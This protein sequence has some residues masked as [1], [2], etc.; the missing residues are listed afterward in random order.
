MERRVTSGAAAGGSCGSG[1]AALEPPRRSATS[2]EVRFLIRPRLRPSVRLSVSVR[3]RVRVRVSLGLELRVR[4]GVETK[5][6]AEL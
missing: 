3:V 2:D 6:Q 5:A 4:V 1:L